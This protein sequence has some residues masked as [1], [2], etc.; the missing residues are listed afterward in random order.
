MKMTYL[1]NV[2]ELNSLAAA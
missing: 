2:I 1:P